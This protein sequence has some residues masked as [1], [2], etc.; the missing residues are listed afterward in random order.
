MPNQVEGG[1]PLLG[2]QWPHRKEGESFRRPD[3]RLIGFPGARRI[4]LEN[5]AYLYHLGPLF[6]QSHGWLY[7]RDGFNA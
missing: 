1:V 5:I 2:H 7:E 4:R 6:S 3:M